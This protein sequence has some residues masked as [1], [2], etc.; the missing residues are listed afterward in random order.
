MH[1]C[2]FEILTRNFSF[3]FNEQQMCQKSK[4][5]IIEICHEEHCH[6]GTKRFD[7]YAELSNS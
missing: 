2:G 5:I 7:G 4:I 3:L 6:G 1:V